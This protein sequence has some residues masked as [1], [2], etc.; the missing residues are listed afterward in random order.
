MPP[1]SSSFS[2][3]SFFFYLFFKRNVWFPSFVGFLFIS[4]QDMS[5]FSVLNSMVE[6]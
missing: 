5:K 1:S 4:I 3:F 6:L 2:F